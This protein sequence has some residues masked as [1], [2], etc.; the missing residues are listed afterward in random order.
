MLP[1][2]FFYGKNKYFLVQN[3]RSVFM[4][5]A[6]NWQKIGRKLAENWQKIGRI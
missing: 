3:N 4:R 6:E 1:L 2:V 5:L